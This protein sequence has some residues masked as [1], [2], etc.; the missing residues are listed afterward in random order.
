MKFLHT[1]DLHL[2]SPFSGLDVSK[3]EARR[4]EL[5]QTFSKMMRYAREAE[6]DMVIIS[7]DLFDGSYVTRETVLLLE[8][9]FSALSCPVIIA[10]GNHDPASEQ[11][12]WQKM[13]FPEN[14]YIFKC[15]EMT[16][17]SFDELCADVYGYAFTD[18]TVS[19]CI[20][21]GACERADRINILAAHCDI[22]SPIGQYAPT[23]VAALR[24]FGAD[25]C[26]LGHIHT[27]DS[28]NAALG[29]IG[30][31]CGC[32]E[33]RDFGEWGEKGALVV[34]VDKQDGKASVKTE[35][36][37]FSRRVYKIITVNVDG[38]ADASFI[39]ERI[40]SFVSESSLSEE[41]LLR[42][43][44]VGSVDPSLIIN[45]AVLSEDALGLFHL[46]VV[47]KTSPTWNSEDLMAEGGIR[48]ELYRVL[49]PKL[50]SADENERAEGA[51]A[52]R[53]ALGALNGDDLL[54]V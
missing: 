26:A 36:V 4:R 31:Y 50:E 47:D 22:T 28:A 29:N 16:R 46:E 19:K 13:R 35:K 14:V 34:T 32:P 6:L 27:P 2:D 52:L 21:S 43:I 20:I 54:E 30:A 42:V 9:E 51:L 40:R 3:A 17:F 33:G 10:P 49:L 18:P 25:Y 12:I 7:G 1:G 11:S 8:R 48:G 37:R 24:A 5:R 45:T 41:T 44:L 38:A 39:A 23:P 15:Q 53:Y